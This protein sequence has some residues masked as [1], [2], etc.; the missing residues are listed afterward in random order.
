[1]PEGHGLFLYAVHSSDGDGGRRAVFRNGH[2]AGQGTETSEM[3]QAAAFQMGE[4]VPAQS[5]MPQAEEIVSDVGLEIVDSE[6][7]DPETA[8]TKLSAAEA[9]PDV[10]KEDDEETGRAEHE[11]AEME[12]KMEWEEKQQAKKS[13]ER[14][15]LARIA[16][17][18][19]DAAVAAA[20]KQIGADTEK[21]TRRNMKECVA[22]YIQ[23]VPGRTC[24]CPHGDAS[25]Q[26]YDPLFPVH[27]P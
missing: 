10:D 25:L 26:E 11:A 22:E 13:A 7:A 24:I 16:E 23:T 19:D 18:S 17:M 8:G 12:R 2:S 6:M 20:M 5:G 3:Y 9:A 1:M 4:G 21:L 14:E 27:Q 15:K